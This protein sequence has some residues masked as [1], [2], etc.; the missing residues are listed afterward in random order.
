MKEST[1]IG[2]GTRFTINTMHNLSKFYSNH[3]SAKLRYVTH[4]TILAIF[5]ISI[6]WKHQSKKISNTSSEI[7]L[8]ISEA[9]SFIHK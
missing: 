4:Y 1:K 9:I 7:R 5:F 8:I 2:I 3:K 6:L